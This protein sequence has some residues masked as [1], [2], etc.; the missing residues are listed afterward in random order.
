VLLVVGVEGGALGL[1]VAEV[2]VGPAEL[3]ADADWLGL[4]GSVPV[5]G[6]SVPAGGLVGA[7]GVAVGRVDDDV[8]LPVTSGATM[9][10][11]CCS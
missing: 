11:I 3:D 7:L 1:P 10:R 2:G 6:V 4:V 8:G 9:A 5:D